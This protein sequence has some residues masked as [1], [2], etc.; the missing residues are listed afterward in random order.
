MNILPVNT[1]IPWTDADKGISYKGTRSIGP[2]ESRVAY[3]L[4]T[5]PKGQNCAYDMDVK[6]NEQFYKAEVKQHDKYSIRTSAS[7]V[8]QLRPTQVKIANLLRL[9]PTIYL[10]T[11]ELLSNDIKKDIK[12]LENVST[13]ELAQNNISKI[14]R[15]CEALYKLYQ[16][17]K[18]STRSFTLHDLRTGEEKK[19][20]PKTYYKMLICDGLSQEDVEKDMGKEDYK[21][22]RLYTD[23]L[24][25]PYIKEPTKFMDDLNNLVNIFNSMLLILVDEN[26]GFYIMTEPNEKLKFERIT[27]GRPRFN[28][29]C[30]SPIL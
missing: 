17:H 2:G 3:R 8:K 6:I 5:T 7:G 11:S 13:D 28:V 14:K 4:Q 16:E 12:S 10:Y 26:K 24:D 20:G 29:S 23:Y 18:P 1:L 22:A 19:V 9:L 25:H 27:Q 21:I 30:I 15:V